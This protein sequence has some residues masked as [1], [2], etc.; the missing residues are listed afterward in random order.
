MSPYFLGKNTN[1]PI[2]RRSF[3][4]D[5]TNIDELY[6][7]VS[8]APTASAGRTIP[9]VGGVTPYTGVPRKAPFHFP[10]PTEGPRE[11]TLGMHPPEDIGEDE[12]YVDELMAS[13]FGEGFETI[14]GVGGR[15]QEAVY[16]LLARQGLLGTGAATDVGKEMAWQT[17]RGITDLIRE[18]GQWR[19]GK[20]Q[21]AMNMLLSFFGMES[22]AW[23]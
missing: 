4:F 2:D 8:R 14:R 16:D 6:R 18:M 10:A 17:E 19:A 7:G 5:V 1:A 20:E 12:S 13:L 3:G 21:E 22:Q 9:V 11:P 23:G 15:S